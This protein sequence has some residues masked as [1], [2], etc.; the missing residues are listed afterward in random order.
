[1]A[2]RNTPIFHCTHSNGFSKLVR[3]DPAHVTV[4]KKVVRV[5][6]EFA[7]ASIVI[8]TL[9][10]PVFAAFGDA[11]VTG[12]HG[13]RWP[14]GR[15]RFLTKY[16]PVSPTI[17][18]GDGFY[19]SQPNTVL[20]LK[21]EEPFTVVLSDGVSLLTGKV[22]DWLLDYGD[23]SLGVVDSCIFTDTYTVQTPTS[24]PYDNA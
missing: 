22:G 20:A 13:E 5:R 7:P 14:V 21:M 8:E 10:G 24:N 4:T 6:V 2:E 1:M 19:Q 9:E 16:L 3:N 17:S 23:G 11:I 18:G 15:E 12:T